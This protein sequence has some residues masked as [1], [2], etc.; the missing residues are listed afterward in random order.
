METLYFDQFSFGIFPC[1]KLITRFLLVIV[2]KAEIS[3]N[4][5]QSSFIYHHLF[6]FVK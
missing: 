1:N 3:E 4:V 5:S 2:I 6:S